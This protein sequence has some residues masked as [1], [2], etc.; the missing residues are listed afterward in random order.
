MPKIRSN[1]PRFQSEFGK[2][3]V[4][5]LAQY[6][7]EESAHAVGECIPDAVQPEEPG[8]VVGCPA[9]VC[10]GVWQRRDCDRLA[11]HNR[12]VVR[13]V[14]RECARRDCDWLVTHNV[15]TVERVCI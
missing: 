6:P 5:T 1:L 8:D 7:Q 3:R 11:T 15:R 13:T 14:E 4:A 12:C 10:L 2:Y 9:Q